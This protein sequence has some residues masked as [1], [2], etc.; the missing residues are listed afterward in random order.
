ML[1][2]TAQFLRGHNFQSNSLE[3]THVADHSYFINS[4]QGLMFEKYAE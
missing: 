4:Q 2:H 1:V 3:A